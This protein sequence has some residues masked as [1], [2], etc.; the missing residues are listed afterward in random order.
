[1]KNVL[2]RIQATNVALLSLAEL[3]E[4]VYMHDSKS[5]LLDISPVFH[6]I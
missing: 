1:M 4:F 6:D 2:T 3:A 5:S